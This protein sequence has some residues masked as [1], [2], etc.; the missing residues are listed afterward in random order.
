[1]NVME[2]STSFPLEIYIF[3]DPID[4]E[5]HYLFSQFVFYMYLVSVFDLVLIFVLDP[6]WNHTL[7]YCYEKIYLGLNSLLF[8]R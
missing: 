2:C 7:I 3:Q 1:M 6:L 8:T 5:S 4:L